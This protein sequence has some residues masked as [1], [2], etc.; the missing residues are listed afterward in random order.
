MEI[1]NIEHLQDLLHQDIVWRKK[2]L[3]YIRLLAQ[4]TTN[5]IFYKVGIALLSAHFEGFIKQAAN[6]YMIYVASQNIDLSKLRT[7]F[8]AICCR[9]DLRKISE[10]DKIVVYTDFINSVLEKINTEKF[11]NFTTKDS[12]INT[13]SNPNSRVFKDILHVIGLNFSRYETKQ[14]YIDSD[15]LN[16]RNRIVHGEKIS[17][18]I[19]EFESTFKIITE[20]M[21]QFMEQILNAAINKEYLRVD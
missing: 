9:K 8:T 11:I 6:Y 1:K 2:E 10:S 17:I 19:N 20:I 3:I 18:D 7:N 15:L 4:S 5:H 12:I 21:E 13:K 14:K 16:N